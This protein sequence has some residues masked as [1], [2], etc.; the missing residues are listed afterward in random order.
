MAETYAYLN[1][2]AR[3]RS[4]AK[5]KSIFTP[6]AAKKI[7]NIARGNFRKTN[8][9]AA[10]SIESAD[11]EGSFVV[12]PKNVKIEDTGLEGL[13]ESFLA[14][15]G[16]RGGWLVP[17]SVVVLLSVLLIVFLTSG[18]NEDNKTVVQAKKTTELT[19]SSNKKEGASSQ[20]LELPVVLDEKSLQKKTMEKDDKDNFLVF[21]TVDEDQSDRMSV[22]QPE[23]TT[24]KNKLSSSQNQ[25]DSLAAQSDTLS[26]KPSPSHADAKQAADSG[27][28][29]A[30]PGIE[31]VESIDDMQNQLTKD[32]HEN[33]EL[34]PGKAGSQV[35]VSQLS[36]Q[37]ETDPAL[38]PQHA[39]LKEN[40]EKSSETIKNNLKKR[41][42]GVQ[43]ETENESKEPSPI[44][45]GTKKSVPP[46]HVSI[47]SP[48]ELYK[49]GRVKLTVPDN[50]D[51]VDSKSAPAK[52]SVF[53]GSLYDRRMVAGKVL[54]SQKNEGIQT[55]QIMAL[56]GEHAEQNLREKLTQQQYRDIAD[57]LYVLKSANDAALYVFYG[58]YPDKNTANQAREHLPL[59]I[60]KND[61]YVISIREAHDK[62]T[63]Y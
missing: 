47:A 3:Q 31:T 6:E 57:N 2:C 18:D 30:L 56:T 39:Q 4:R 42:T 15:L 29:G 28:Q 21:K 58:E 25:K 48:K 32:I 9:I 19:N 11:T 53:A 59:F 26:E 61:P 54:F 43:K 16:R 10:K 46:Q 40:A 63:L 49:I 55:I 8:I 60:R 45:A 51:V 23:A 36:V 20:A 22:D 14:K 50:G 1:H 24:I 5:G 35:M 44:L 37:E 41:V 33:R 62:A 34:Q 13:R 7:F 12:A 27:N 52:G 17:G 38:I